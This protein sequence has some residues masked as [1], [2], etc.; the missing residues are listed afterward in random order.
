MVNVFISNL[1]EQNIPF[2]KW[3]KAA[4]NSLRLVLWWGKY[5]NWLCPYYFRLYFSCCLFV[6]DVFISPSFTRVQRASQNGRLYGHLWATLN[7]EASASWVCINRRCTRSF[8]VCR[9]PGWTEI[10]APERWIGDTPSQ[11]WA[12]NLKFKHKCFLYS[13]NCCA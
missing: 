13:T 5:T 10:A 7:C 6:G 8:Q 3:R 4:A 1:L 2:E 9:P 11:M 12:G